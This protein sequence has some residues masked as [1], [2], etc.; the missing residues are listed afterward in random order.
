MT[1]EQELL[2]CFSNEIIRPWEDLNKELSRHC[3]V[4]PQYSLLTNKAHALATSLKHISEANGGPKSKEL[5]DLSESYYII[6]DLA[7]TKKHGERNDPKRT[8]SI[9]SASRYERK[10]DGVVLLRFL[11]NTITIKHETLGK[12]DFMECSKDCALFLVEHLKIKH[13]WTPKV[14]DNN[15]EFSNKVVTHATKDNQTIWTGMNWEIVELNDKKEY[16]FVDLHGTI[17]FH[18]ISDF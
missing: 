16:V 15:A 17:E 11:R 4:S 14:Y 6:S 7:D 18:L 8:C 2:L 5:N 9:T 3:S 13:T 12:R 10:F 1:K